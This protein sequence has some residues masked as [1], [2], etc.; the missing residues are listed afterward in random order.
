[1]NNHQYTLCYYSSGGMELPSLSKG[2]AD[3]RADGGKVR[4]IARTQSQL[5]HEKQRRRFID[6]AI[7]ADVVIII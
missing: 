2:L 1:M 5:F 3:Y 7:A 6:Q 4:V